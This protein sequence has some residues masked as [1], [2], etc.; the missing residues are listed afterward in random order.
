MTTTI[1][2]AMAVLAVAVALA[3]CQKDMTE[4]LSLKNTGDAPPTVQ[5]ITVPERATY[6]LYSSKEP[7]AD[8]YSRELKRGDKIGFQVRGNRVEATAAG[9]IIELEEYS[10]G[11]SYVWKKEEKKKE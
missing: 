7:N 8:K 9:S 6:R 10:E 4:V 3:G 11:A 5:E 1:S 2:R